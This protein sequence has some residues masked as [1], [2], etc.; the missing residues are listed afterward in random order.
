V[1]LLP[2]VV[3]P[4]REF[5]RQTVDVWS[6][7]VGLLPFTSIN[8][9][10]ISAYRKHLF[11]DATLQDLPDDPPCFVNNATNIQSGALWRFSKPYMRDYLVGE[12]K[13]PKLGR[14]V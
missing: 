7:V 4:L 5:A 11:G 2:E 14:G 13:N 6:I 12:V 1:D 8:A 9:R 3:E 10:V